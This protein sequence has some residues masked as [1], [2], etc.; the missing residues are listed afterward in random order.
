MKL[1]IV[2]PS[3][4]G[5]IV[6]GLFA[7]SLLKSALPQAELWWVANDSLVPLLSLA[8]GIHPLPF[9][10]KALGRLSLTALRQFLHA[11]R[12]ESFDAVLDFQ[13]LLRSGLITFFAKAPK[14]YGFAHAREG[15]T[16]FYNRKVTVPEGVRHAVEKN[17]LL[18]RTFLRDMGREKEAEGMPPPLGADLPLAWRQ[19]AETLMQEHGLAG[20]PMLA[21][22]CASRWPSKSWPVEYFAQVLQ[23][24]LRRK[25]ETA[26]WLLGSPDERPRAEALQKLAGLPES[27]VLAGK[28]S[29]GGLCA[30]LQRS[31][32]L[33]TNDSG[34]MHIAAL[35]GV[36]CVAN[37]G[38]TDPFL[39]GPYGP[40]G[41]H[42]IV[43]SPCPQSPCLKRNCPRGD[44]ALCCQ[45]IA[46]R[47]VAEWLLQRLSPPG[48]TPPD[49]L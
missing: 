4:L 13:G 3:S 37:F 42:A 40:A 48:N 12:Q 23:E 14:R 45:G 39:T 38:S 21:V 9:P 22:E 32:V 49:A 29:M 16:L 34:P 8:P 11:L 7:I 28:T 46:P 26:V 35:E 43:P 30:L 6:H 2:K 44:N 36:P 17:L 24:V 15:A 47:Q 27:A 10:R 33:F 20:K 1:L 18:V 25:P 19:E 41:L 31:R 5:D